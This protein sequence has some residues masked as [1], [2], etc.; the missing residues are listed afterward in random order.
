MDIRDAKSVTEAVAAIVT[1]HGRITHLVN[2]AGGQF[3]SPVGEISE[4]GWQS[5]IDLN[6]TGTWRVM[7]AVYD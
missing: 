3:L 1:K 7:R 4:R 6:L 2:C 5:V